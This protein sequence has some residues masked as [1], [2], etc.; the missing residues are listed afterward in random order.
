N[1]LFAFDKAGEVARELRGGLQIGFDRVQM[2][3]MLAF[4]VAGPAAEKGAPLK[5]RLKW[6]GMPEFKWLGRLDV[7]MSVNQKMR[8]RG[9]ALLKCSCQNNRI[10]FRGTKARVQS[11]PFAMLA[12]PFCAG[13]D[14]LLVLRLG[15]DAREA[16]VVAQLL[17]KTGLI[18][19]EV[20]EH[21][22]HRR[23]LA[24]GT[25]KC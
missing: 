16:N 10:A 22:L 1:L 13:C 19:F 2:G 24:A 17:D 8:I 6:G 15:R 14:I 23:F 25:P 21:F 5:A 18:F 7:I 4:V 3:Q 9:R 12:E 11:N 20:L